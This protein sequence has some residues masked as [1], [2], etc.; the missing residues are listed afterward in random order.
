MQDPG[1]AGLIDRAIR[2]TSAY[3]VPRGDGRYL[4][5]GTVEEKGWDSAPTAGG[6]F[7][8]IRDLFEVLPG[9]LELELDQICVGFR[10]GTPDNLPLIGES[11]VEGVFL[12]TGHYRNGVLLTPI[13]GE[14]ITRAV[15]GEELPDWAE[16]CSPK[17]FEI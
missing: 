2:T 15:I 7:E 16:A 6:V 5:G 8:L 3:L 11:T 13:T 14:L 12:A 17:R 1:G 10:P 4:L 9:V